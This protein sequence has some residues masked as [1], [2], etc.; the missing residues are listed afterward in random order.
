MPAVQRVVGIG[1]SAGGLEA[2]TAT[3]GLIPT[4]L[5]FCFI[6]AQH[7]APHYDSPL[8]KLLAHNAQIAV[9]TATDGSPLLANTALVAPPDVDILVEDD[10]VRLQPSTG[11]GP[12]PRIDEMLN[13]LATSHGSLAIALVLSGS[14]S[15]GAHGARRVHDGGGVV[16]VQDPQSAA[17]PEMPQATIDSGCADLI[18]RP[19]QIAAALSSLPEPIPIDS[20]SV[21]PAVLG[22][23]DPTTGAEDEKSG[24]TVIVNELRRLTGIDFAGYKE[25]TLNRQISRRMALT[26]T[27][28]IPAYRDLLLSDKQEV[29]SL[30][31]ALLVGVTSF[32]RDPE[33]W[34]VLKAR[35]Q[36]A[37]AADMDRERRIWV[38]GCSTGE[39]AY[40]IAMVAA[41]VLGTQTRPSEHLKVFATDLSEQALTTARRGWYDDTAVASIPEY[42]RERWWRPQGKGWEVSPALRDAVIFARHN[43]TSDPPFPR[44]DLICIRNTLIYFQGS[45]QAQAL[46]MFCYSLLPR[47]L[48]FL[49]NAERVDDANV[50]FK[51]VDRGHRIYVRT[52]SEARDG[53]P[54]IAGITGARQATNLSVPDRVRDSVL[55]RL[56][57]PSL[58]VDD[59]D[60]VVEV[61][62][63]VGPWCWVAPGA[64]STQLVALLRDELRVKVRMLLLMVRHEDRDE[65]EIQLG[66][67]DPPVAI[68]AQL[69]GAAHPGFAVISF[70]EMTAPVTPSD[71]TEQGTASTEALAVAQEL[72]I[73]QAALQ[74]TVEDLSSSNEELR[75][76]N[77]ELQASS[78]EAQSAI[79]ELQATNEELSTVNQELQV[80]TNALE[81]AN[82]DLKNIQDSVSAG[83]ILVDRDLRVTRFT[84]P[85]VRVFALIAE[86]IGRELSTIPTTMELG[87]IE[88]GLREAIQHGQQKI[89]NVSGQGNDFLLQ[90]RPYLGDDGRVLGAVLV[91]TDVTEVLDAHRQVAAALAQLNAATDAMDEVVWQRDSSGQL[92]LLSSGVENVFGLQR[93]R[94][95]ADP[96]L[97]LAAVHP[98]DRERVGLIYSSINGSW[99][100]RYRIR[101]PDG[102]LRW[103]QDTSMPVST[104]GGSQLANGFIRDITDL[105]TTEHAHRMSQGM[106]DAFCDLRTIG[107]VTLSASGK[108]LSANDYLNSLSGYSTADLL[109][110]P[111][112]ALVTTLP[113]QLVG[114]AP[115][116]PQHR[117]VA[118]DQ[119]P[120]WV[121]VEVHSVPEEST[122]FGEPADNTPRTLV[123][124]QDLTPSLEEAENLE[125]EVRFDSQTG[126]LARSAFHRRVEVEISRSQRTGRNLGV[127]WID[128]DRFKEVNETHGHRT[129][130][131]VL[132]SVAQRLGRVTQGLDEVGRLGGDE[133]GILVPDIEGAESI[134]LVCQ[135]IL[136]AVCEP[137]HEG[138]Q[139]LYVTASIGVAVAPYDG[140]T[141]DQLLHNANTAMYSVK[142]QGGDASAYFQ[143]RM[144]EEA[145]ARGM[146]RQELA[147][148]VRARSFTMYY[149]PLIDLATGKPVAVEGLI[150]WVTD[151]G[152]ITAGSFLDDARAT[153]LL[154][155]IGRIGRALID[156]DLRRFDTD[157]SLRHLS[158]G[159]NLA[160]EE[161]E[162]SE[163]MQNVVRWT[164]PGGMHRLMIEITEQSLLPSSGTTM[165]TLLVLQRLGAEICIDDFGT[166]FSNVAVLTQLR[167]GII[168]MDRSLV[169]GALQDESSQR[170]LEAS[171]RM[172]Q[173]LQAKVVVEG[174]E[175]ADQVALAKDL[176]ADYGQGFHFARP[177]PLS[178]LPERLQTID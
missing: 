86:D 47:G 26:G 174:I 57:P 88:G 104:E 72:Q 103:I 115:H 78:E 75:A 113:E 101:R 41:D 45:L 145:Q 96:G 6:I 173:A 22:R 33:S 19:E 146:R 69:L 12:H 66:D 98:E 177:V 10:H 97:L 15:D 18:L 40:T 117:L 128:L 127:L 76:L 156:S 91:L 125:H 67:S 110:M 36:Q 5:P 81:H 95:L 139:R 171:I 122:A 87:D 158:V 105:V 82:S 27:H 116:R 108:I 8:T 109:G 147:A 153:G 144:N 21:P 43:V 134:E 162:D 59:N 149:Q 148:A 48:L 11:L 123:V 44:L 99:N 132:N 102:T 71:E 39:E 30:T 14:G 60:D 42:L 83:L 164:P 61:V 166:G 157:E 50:F 1:S 28:D 111:I 35:L 92:L 142:Q 2:L 137:M 163:L 151:D 16:I 130:D 155:S 165:E 4:D 159:I 131:F 161:L 7:M 150:R 3:L 73:T 84:P 138:D 168:K 52:D 178:E 120:R 13:S 17:F 152:V 121:S 79:E 74:S 118:K 124:I 167:P 55:S 143:T 114:T 107:V 65:A 77:E 89:V 80:R 106:A 9:R 53:L 85:A 58:V 25:G 176:G 100:I 34:A 64:P 32:F 29:R 68:R 136:A 90:I 38:P 141:A 129:G 63:D 62:G 20:D 154:R 133:F 46:R 94:V 170:L 119:T 49:G 24:R 175:T 23:P 70:H 54:D 37:W 112:W 51:P 31:A 169:A 135:R 126:V 56:L 140:S 93:D 160:A 172:A